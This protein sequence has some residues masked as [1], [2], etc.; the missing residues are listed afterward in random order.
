MKNSA[1]LGPAGTELLK[2]GPFL[3]PLH[4]DT[5]H[6]TGGFRGHGNLSL[7]RELTAGLS[8]LELANHWKKKGTCILQRKVPRGIALDSP[9]LAPRC[10]HHLELR[11]TAGTK[12]ASILPSRYGTARHTSRF[13]RRAFPFARVP[14]LAGSDKLSKT[15]SCTSCWLILLWCKKQIGRHNVIHVGGL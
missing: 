1:R 3:L 11:S 5:G 13:R 2:L 15:C 8:H 6:G 4:P 7:R 9:Y 10:H 12:A 14:A